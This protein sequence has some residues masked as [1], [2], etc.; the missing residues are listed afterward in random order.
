MDLA[1]KMDADPTLAARSDAQ[2]AADID[3]AVARNAAQRA[4]IYK[5]LKNL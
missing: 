1:R 2:K 3:T 4:E 5:R